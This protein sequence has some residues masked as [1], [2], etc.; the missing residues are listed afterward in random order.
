MPRHWRL[1]LRD[2][3]CWSGIIFRL[4]NIEIGFWAIF[5]IFMS[6]PF[7][8]P[9]PKPHWSQ[10]P[11]FWVGIG[12]LILTAILVVLTIIVAWPQI[13]SWISGNPN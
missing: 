8:V 11:S 9:P 7:P 12:L 13:H 5:L 4:W 2:A 1:S 3:C 10:I 6:G